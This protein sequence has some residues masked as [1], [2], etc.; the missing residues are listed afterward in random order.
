MPTAECVRRIVHLFPEVE[1]RLTWDSATFR[2]RDRIFALLGPEEESVTVRARPAEQ[3]A[4]LTSGART[5]SPAPYTG[6]FSWVWVRLASVD[7]EQLH[8]LLAEAWHQAAPKHVAARYRGP[9]ANNEGVERYDG[10]A[11]RA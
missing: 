2:V 7:P 1:E 8:E 9:S 5:F 11:G 6:R 10:R 3:Y 4:L